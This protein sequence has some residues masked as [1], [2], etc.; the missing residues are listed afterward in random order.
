MS[1]TRSMATNAVRTVR[2]DAELWTKIEED[3]RAIGTNPSG[4]VRMLISHYLG[5][6]GPPPRPIYRTPPLSPEETPTP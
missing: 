1:Y 5:L 2:V 6:A 3:A 4:L